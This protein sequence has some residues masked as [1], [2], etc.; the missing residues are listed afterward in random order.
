LVLHFDEP[1]TLG[2]FLFTHDSHFPLCR[3]C[4][5][6][7]LSFSLYPREIYDPTQRTAATRNRP[8]TIRKT[9]AMAS[10]L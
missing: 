4:E 5:G 7:P 9:E 3:V 8:N 2:L 6:K 1:H 10:A